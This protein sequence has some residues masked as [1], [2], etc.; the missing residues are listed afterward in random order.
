[1]N[2]TIDTSA[3]KTRLHELIAASPALNS[4]PEEAR[5]YRVYVML[6]SKPEDMMKFIQ[7]LETEQGD[8]QK[9]DDEYMKDLQA[10]QDLMTQVKE[11]EAEANREIRKEAEEKVA[12][13]DQQ[14]AEDILKQMDAVT[15]GS[16]EEQPKKKKGWFN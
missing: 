11:L 12:V 9:V 4:L 13:V 16:K 3:L 14:K 1:M 10:L 6:D 7:I 2:T 15:G 8:M 5:Q